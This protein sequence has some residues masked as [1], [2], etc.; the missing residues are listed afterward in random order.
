MPRLPHPASM[1]ENG[2]RALKMLTAHFLASRL[3]GLREGQR[4]SFMDADELAA[5]LEV[6]SRSART[7]LGGLVRKGYAERMNVYR[8]GSYWRVTRAGIY[9]ALSL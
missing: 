9:A 3:E 4:R 8:G 5:L 2:L 6:S 1:S 7:Y